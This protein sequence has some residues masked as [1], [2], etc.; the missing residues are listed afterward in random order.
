MKQSSDLN[1]TLN[2]TN[3]FNQGNIKLTIKQQFDINVTNLFNQK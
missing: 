1:K 2:Q 3:S